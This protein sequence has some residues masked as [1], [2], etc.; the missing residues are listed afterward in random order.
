[1]Q[2]VGPRIWTSLGVTIATLPEKAIYL[3]WLDGR[4]QERARTW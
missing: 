3:D 1:M 4:R 2:C